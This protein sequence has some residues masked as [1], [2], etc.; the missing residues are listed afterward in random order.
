M[1]E[2][3]FWLAGAIA[4]LAGLLC[5]VGAV[6]V[7]FPETQLGNALGILVASGF[8][9]LNIVFCYALYSVIRAEA[10]GHA[11]R[12][13]LLFAVVAFAT[14]LS[15]LCVQQAIM[16]AVPE[17]T[18]G[19]DEQTATTLR[20]SLRMVDMGLDVAWDFLIGSGMICFGL[21]MRG[22]RVLRRIWAPGYI[23]LGGALILLN[24]ATFPWPPATRGL[25]DIGP[26]IGLFMA[27]LAVRILVFAR[28][29]GREATAPQP[30]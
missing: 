26:F 28:R 3:R 18:A 9:I 6:A 20:R 27:A 30:V 25:F 15:M 22:H 7:P 13:G 19:M 17:L 11:N 24:A 4:G 21:A 10:P 2:D 12:L 8:A 5:Y 29:A 14:L 16:M 23:L 1:R